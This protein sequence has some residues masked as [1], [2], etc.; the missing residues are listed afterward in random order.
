VRPWPAGRKFK[1]ESTGGVAA[2]SP[3]M[4]A[5]GLLGSRTA[6]PQSHG[7]PRAGELDS[8]GSCFRLFW[9]P[10][11][12]RGREFAFVWPCPGRGTEEQFICNG[13]AGFEA[14]TVLGKNTRKMGPH[15]T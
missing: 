3:P 15:G 7:V 6:V 4:L 9:E 14:P 2:L 10:L 13:P 5:T 11:S 12:S 1:G 8:A